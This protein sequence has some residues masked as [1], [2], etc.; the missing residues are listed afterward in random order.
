VQQFDQRSLEEQQNAQRAAIFRVYNYYRVLIGFLFLFLFLDSNL[1][2]FVG[3]VNP[4]LF[5]NTIITYLAVNI[6][7]G[8]AT[9]FISINLLSRTA[10]AFIV[11][12]GDIIA[13][14]L[15]M[16]ASGGVA[17]GLGNFLFFTLAFAG[18]LVHGRVSTV[19][20]AIAFI[21]TIY[22]ELY[23]FFLDENDIQSFFQAGLLGIVYF[24]TNILFQTL[25]NQLRSRQSE[26]YTLEQMNQI[27]IEGMSTGVVVLNNENH[28][29]LMNNAAERFL[30]LPDL[31]ISALRSNL[32][33]ELLDVVAAWQAEKSHGDSQKEAVFTLQES[34][35]ELRATISELPSS[36]SDKETLVFLQDNT[37]VQR[38]AQQLKLA[39]LGRLSASIAH[40]IRNPLGA[41]SHA[42]QLLQESPNLDKGDQRLCDIVQDHSIRMND[43]IENVLQMSRRQSPE[44]VEINVKEW[45]GNFISNFRA[46]GHEAAD[47]TVEVENPDITIFIDPSH[48]NQVMTNLCQ[49]GLRYSEKETGKAR[50]VI[51]CQS[52]ELLNLVHLDVVDYGTGV[53]VENLENLFEPF[54]T[55]ET[56][57]TG[58]G[59]YLSRELCAANDARLSYR[60]AETGGAMFR[61]SVRNH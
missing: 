58:L 61:I 54:Y 24:V 36:S 19:L 26:V 1:N 21:L 14:T 44:R 13:L 55:T 25:S 33:E 5:R 17:S 49:N 42:A 4:N 32:P 20:P 40:E 59:L 11:L 48:L 34:S 57:G 3:N 46:G 6:V 35:M 18:G 8:I 52:D 16:S 56:T 22:N 29:R 53:A 23:L 51:T 47:I 37:E 15:L 10:P 38:Q 30:A 28:A 9:L 60:Q 41:I 39:S 50:L 45:L 27:I 12:I 43:V 7:I 31:E 2:G